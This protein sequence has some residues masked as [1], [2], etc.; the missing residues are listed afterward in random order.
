[1]AMKA[2]PP[3]IAARDSP[4]EKED[5]EFLIPERIRRR[6]TDLPSG[7][8]GNLPENETF[9]LLNRFNSGEVSQP[10]ATR[11]D[12]VSIARRAADIA[13]RKPSKAKITDKAPVP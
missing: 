7:K 9:H 1:M 5:W 11:Q 10:S 12:S 4:E 8:Q 3:F 2:R 13:T 6:G